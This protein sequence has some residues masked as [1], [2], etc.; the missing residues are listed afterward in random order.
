MSLDSAHCMAS[1][2]TI[3]PDYFSSSY[4]PI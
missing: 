4:I 3:R 1:F 2:A